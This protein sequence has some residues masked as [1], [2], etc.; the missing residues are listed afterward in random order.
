MCGHHSRSSFN[1]FASQL[2]ADG[3]GAEYAEICF[4]ASS[5]AKRPMSSDM[6]CPA[7]HLL[8]TGLRDST[9]LAANKLPNRCR[10]QAL[11]CSVCNRY[12]SVVRTDACPRMNSICLISSAAVWHSFA[13]ILRRS[14]G[15]R[16]SSC[17]RSAHLR[18]SY[19]MT[20][21]EMPFSYAVPCRSTALKMRPTR[22]ARLDRRARS[23]GWMARPG[24]SD[25]GAAFGP[26]GPDYL[27]EGGF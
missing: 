23:R 22:R 20:F 10:L 14:C 26:E 24:D 6:Q 11:Q 18:T 1:A 19:Q 16:W 8:P 9:V 27:S 2:K 17:V 13:K 25:P 12:R 15:A 7:D 4:Q 21:S 5:M 3:T